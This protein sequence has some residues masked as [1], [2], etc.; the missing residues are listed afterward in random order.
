[1]KTLSTWVDIDLDAL[2]SNIR[3]IRSLVGPR[4]R[5]H[6]VVKADAYGHGAFPVARVAEE[7]GVH[8]VGVATLD[9]G[10]ELRRD[11]E[12]MFRLDDPDPYTRG[13]FGLRTTKSHIRVRDFS[14]R[15]ARP[16]WGRV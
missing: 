2:A 6:L 8:S 15:T 1:M 11:G 13:H 7:E 12:T 5:I 14:V 10:I 3:L 4:V 16:A 9:E